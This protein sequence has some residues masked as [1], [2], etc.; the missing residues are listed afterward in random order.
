M[1]TF[2]FEAT[3]NAANATD[4]ALSRFRN[5]PIKSSLT[6]IEGL[7]GKLKVFRISGSKYWQVRLYN[8]GRYTTRSLKTTDLEE[9]KKLARD[10]FESLQEAGIYKVK[11]PKSTALGEFEN[12]RLLFDLIK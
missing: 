7:P 2:D 6:A 10:F 12:Q 11:V 3:S 5:A 8:L 9:A 4:F 1:M